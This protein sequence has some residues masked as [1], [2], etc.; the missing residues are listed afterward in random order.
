[1]TDALAEAQRVLEREEQRAE[2]R[3]KEDETG[4]RHW[5]E[6]WHRAASHAVASKLARA[7]LALWPECDYCGKERAFCRGKD[8]HDNDMCCEKCCPHSPTDVCEPIDAWIAAGGRL[9]VEPR[10]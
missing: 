10:E 4:E 2:A 3:R 5:D 6:A 1:M 7:V 9:H 8:P